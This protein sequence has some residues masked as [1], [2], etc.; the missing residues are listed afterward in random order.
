M[1][2]LHWKN[3]TLVVQ[4]SMK[5]DIPLFKHLFTDGMQI[6]SYTSKENISSHGPVVLVDRC[7]E[8]F[9]YLGEMPKRRKP[10]SFLAVTTCQDHLLEHLKKVDLP[11]SLYATSWENLAEG[12]VSRILTLRDKEDVAICSFW[13]KHPKLPPPCLHSAMGSEL[14]VVT[15]DYDPE[16]ALSDCSEAKEVGDPVPCRLKGRTV[17][18]FDMLADRCNFTWRSFRDPYGTWGSLPPEGGTANESTGSFRTT[19]EWKA[20]V[21]LAPWETTSRRKEWLDFTVPFSTDRKFCFNNPADSSYSDSL[22]LWRPF[23][24]GTWL[25]TFGLLGMITLLVLCASSRS[26]AAT[27]RV[28]HLTGGL[29]FAAIHAFYGGA[30]TMFLASTTYTPFDTIYEAVTAKGEDHTLLLSKGEEFTISNFFDLNDPLVAEANERYTSEEYSKTQSP[31]MRGT[32]LELARI[33][34]SVVIAPESRVS[35]HLEKMGNEGFTINTFCDPLYSTASLMLPKNSP[36]LRTLN[37]AIIKLQEN[38]QGRQLFLKWYKEFSKTS[39]FDSS[40]VTLGQMSLATILFSA[41]Y[42]L[43]FAIFVGELLWKRRLF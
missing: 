8:D 28:A 16:V 12:N 14:R 1:K 9:S 10:D 25:A 33:P 38:G 5:K 15:L 24:A 32:L 35:Y 2:Y 19:I 4:K 37:S 41:L 13:L 6:A 21:P 42:C 30:L 29:M 40:G 43:A 18:L 34:N 31:T 22:F 26:G 39:H 36:F 27:T 23:T 17:D 20:D 3:A 7:S 11:M